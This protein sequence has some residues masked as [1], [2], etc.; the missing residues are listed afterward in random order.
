MNKSSQETVKYGILRIYIYS[1]GK[2]DLEHFSKEKFSMYQYET[3]GEGGG[4]EWGVGRITSSVFT[5]FLS[6]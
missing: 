3:L 5:N 2:K 6:S 1:T 4:G